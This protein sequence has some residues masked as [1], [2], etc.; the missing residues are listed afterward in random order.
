MSTNKHDD[1]PECGNPK[2]VRSWLCR[3]CRDALGTHKECRCCRKNLPI[4][5]FRLRTR[6][7]PRPRSRCKKCEASAQVARYAA[8]P[9]HLRKIATRRWEKNNPKKYK[10]LLLRARCRKSGVPEDQL[11]E[12]IERM[13]KAKNCEICNRPFKKVNCRFRSPHL[14]HCHI[15]GVFRGILCSDCNF[16]LGNFDDSTERLLRAVLYLLKKTST[17]PADPQIPKLLG[18]LDQIH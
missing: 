13:L 6:K 3:A 15:S 18:I 16:G 8:K 2:D 4:S 7:T 14:D 1:C 9:A 10:R 17:S 12:T 11:E 5:E